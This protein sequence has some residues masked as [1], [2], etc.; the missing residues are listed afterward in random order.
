MY[1][2]KRITNSQIIITP[3]WMKRLSFFAEQDYNQEVIST[4]ILSNYGWIAKTDWF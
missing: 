3:P 4:L 2:K 1:E